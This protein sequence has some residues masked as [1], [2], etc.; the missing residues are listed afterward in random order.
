L[1]LTSAAAVPLSPAGAQEPEIE[2]SAQPWRIVLAQQ[3]HA[4]KTCDLSEILY[5]NEMEI[6]GSMT[7]EGRATCVDGRHFDFS[8]P[9]VH[10]KFD[11][12]MCEP[13]V[14]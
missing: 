6:G 9:R 4:E 2:P 12:R 5:F 3:L 1:A 13:A 11:L 10:Q 14:C 7:L 8:R